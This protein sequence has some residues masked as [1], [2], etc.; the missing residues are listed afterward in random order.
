MASIDPPDRIGFDPAAF[1]W[2]GVE[3]RAYKEGSRPERGMAWKG[4]SRHTLMSSPLAGAGFETRYFEFEP[5]GYSSLEKHRHVHFVV[6][7]RGA[8]RALVGDRVHALS[9]FDAVYVP[10][11]V[12]HR[13]LNAGED[14]PFGFLCTVDGERDRPG[15]LDEEE[16][17][18]LRLAPATTAYVF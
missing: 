14:E 9:P 2:E 3:E 6:A 17:E 5:G 4:V 7:I 13:W 18:R 11:L 16:W 8:G 12:P 1:R 10:P 15:A